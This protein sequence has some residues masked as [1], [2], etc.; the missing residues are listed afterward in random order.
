MSSIF[1]E[2]K[3]YKPFKFPW[4]MELAIEQNIDLY[5]DTHELD[6]SV[7]V[8]Q[9]HSK[10]GL[11]TENVSHA[12]NKN[13]L[14]KILSIFTQMD[15]AAGSLYCKLL[16][17]VGNNEIR[18]MWVTF[19]AKECVHQRGYALGVEE[20]GFP[21]S[22]W[23]E[24]MEYDE[25]HK[26]IDLMSNIGNRDL[27]NKLDFAKTIAQLLLS[28]GICLFGAFACM[29]NLKRF[30]ILLG[31]NMVNEWSLKEE[32]K[33]VEGNIR[34]LSE[35]R[36]EL[37]PAEK[38]ELD[39]FI[40]GMVDK[41][42]LAEDKFIDLVF[43]MGPQEQMTPSDMKTY[44]RYLGDLRLSQL[45]LPPLYDVDENPLEWLDWMLT[46]KKH[47]NFF[48]KKVTDYDHS[49]LVGKIDYSVYQ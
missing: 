30:G 25:M 40:E 33:H 16:P 46:G 38:M 15:V 43:E 39:A 21:D 31:F 11:A 2:S 10:N 35:V 42:V 32:Q 19:A 49:G 23:A 1:E 22:T 26:K 14:E 5:W 20:F 7:D 13:M 6:L 44:I 4:A 8:P 18:T 36:K 37:T 9:F 24:F 47:G 29:L 45:N 17:H 48:E 34:V 41:L 12:S 3:T 28:E 27:S